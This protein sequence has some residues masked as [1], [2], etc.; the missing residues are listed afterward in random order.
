MFQDLVF[1]DNLYICNYYKLPYK[2]TSKD[3]SYYSMSIN[4]VAAIWW[5][6]LENYPTRFD[7][8][9]ELV[10]WYFYVVFSILK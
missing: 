5:G 10:E 6:K 3:D 2:I 9:L 7:K 4:D 8:W 1:R